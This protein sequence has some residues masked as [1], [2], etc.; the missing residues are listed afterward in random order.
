MVIIRACLWEV[1]VSDAAKPMLTEESF[2]VE[3]FY[4]HIFLVD[5]VYTFIIA[6]NS[7]LN[8]GVPPEKIYGETLLA[9][10]PSDY[11]ECDVQNEQDR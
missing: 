5:A 8:R 6:I 1:L 9:E 3:P 10:V 11:P 4:F 2:R 7:L